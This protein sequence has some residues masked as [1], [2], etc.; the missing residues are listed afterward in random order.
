MTTTPDPAALA[1]PE[2]G[3]SYRREGAALVRAQPEAPADPPAAP[4]PPDPEPE[5]P[6][7]EE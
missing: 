4:P 6:A 7:G 5:P 2:T 1:W 3:G